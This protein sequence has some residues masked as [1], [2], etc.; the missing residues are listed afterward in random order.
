MTDRQST[1]WATIA[2]LMLAATLP[3]LSGGIVN[4]VLP[5]IEAAF[6]SVPNAGVLAQ[7]VSTL[8]GLII[9]IFAPIIGV[10]VDRYGRKS[11]LI[12][13]M[14]IYGIGPSLAYFLDSLYLILGT[15]IFLGIAVAGIMVSV[16]TLIADYFTGKRR[17]TV[18]G[19]QGAMMP[20]GAAVAMIAGGIMADLNWRTVFL[21]YLIALLMVP[22]V[23][24]FIDEPD[25]ETASDGSSLP[26]LTELRNILGE[27]PLA[28][29]TGVYLTMFIGMIGYNQINVEIPFYLQMVTSV[30]GTMT[31]IA[32]AIVS[33]VA[34][35][36]SLNFDRIRERFS[37]ISII[38]GIFAA[39]GIGF[40]VASVTESYW[41]IVTGIVIAGAGLI[42]LTP[43][44]NY[45]VAARV[46]EQ[47]RGR[48]LSGVT[49]TQFLGMFI[50]PIAAEPLIA[51]LGTGQALLAIGGLGFALMVLFVV[52]GLRQRSNPGT[53]P[54]TQPN[55]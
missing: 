7:L 19:W 10:L 15:R 45:W 31:G 8:T 52:V 16:T 49:T 46:T 14:I 35:L 33:I 32:I 55:D 21:T 37:P 47:Y 5:A 41:I 36:V 1:P 3:A 22:L 54:A 13:S 38:A 51:R 18:M 4:P 6:P 53:T 9:A 43:T 39:T 11:V 26:S 2:T 25:V 50:S 29:L 27:L 12:V 34:G 17:E 20:F 30:S 24:R 42:L 44:I 23:V 48:A 28:F 40:I